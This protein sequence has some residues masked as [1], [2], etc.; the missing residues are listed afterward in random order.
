MSTIAFRK[1]TGLYN[2]LLLLVGITF[3]LTWLPALRALFDGV[4]YQWGTSYFGMTFGG[5][6]LNADYFYLLLQLVFY[7]ILIWSFYR[8]RNRALNYALLGIWWIHIFG[9]LLFEIM[10][11]GDTMFHGDTLNVHVSLSA[12]V[13]PL[14]LL[15]L[16]LIMLVARRDMA[17]DDENIPWSRKNTMIALIVF[18][19]LPLQA[20]FFASGEP[21][22]I[23][24]QVAVKV[25]ILQCLLIPLVVRPYR[26][27][28]QSNL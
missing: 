5:K 19:P 7:A 8:V 11:T 3:M 27:I 22:G 21:H 18:G 12:I 10:A 26:E 17:S 15:A 13:I 6:G 28:K 1:S 20:I 16:V 25:S 24:D 4:S 9:N 14:S 23:T 2:G